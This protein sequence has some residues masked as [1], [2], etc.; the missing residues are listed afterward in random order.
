[1]TDDRK[2]SRFYR[3]SVIGF[4]VILGIDKLNKRNKQTK[5]ELV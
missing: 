5:T 3:S 2:I 1:M 4:I